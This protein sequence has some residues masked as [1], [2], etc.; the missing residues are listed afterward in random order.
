MRD[1]QTPCCQQ[2]IPDDIAATGFLRARTHCLFC[3]TCYSQQS[4]IHSAHCHI[5]V[6]TVFFARQQNL[7][8]CCS[9]DTIIRLT[10]ITKV[11]F[12]TC[13]SHE[14][15]ALLPV[16]FRELRVK[17]VAIGSRALYTDNS[18]LNS[19][20]PLFLSSTY[21]SQLDCKKR[22]ESLIIPPSKDKIT[23]AQTPHHVW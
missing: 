1:K 12:G 15:I 18:A 7:L 13:G 9:F 8:P 5:N 14:V 10:I 19:Q 21:C 17:R 11:K 23:V 4:L 22:S 6:T 2:Q 20:R 16:L 3:Q